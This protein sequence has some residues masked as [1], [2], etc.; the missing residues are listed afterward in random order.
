M[1]MTADVPDDASGVSAPRGAGQTCGGSVNKRIGS[2]MARLR[3]RRL[4]RRG[5]IVVAATGLLVGGGGIAFA[6]VAASGPIDGS[7]VIHGCYTNAAIN[8]SH[9]I[10]LQNAGTNCPSGTTAITWGSQGTNG[11]NGVSPTVASFTGSEGG[12]TNGGD[13]ITDADQN[14]TYVCDGTNGSDGSPGAPGLTGPSTAG[15]DGL[16]TTTVTVNGV[17]DATAQCPAA[18]PYILGGGAND[19]TITNGTFGALNYDGLAHAG[20]LGTAAEAPGV[21]YGWTGVAVTNT[22]TV[23]AFAICSD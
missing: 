12:C 21:A 14:T 1:C 20:Q 19:D 4:G 17:G 16:N 5:L 18:E 22:D 15:P 23:T 10:V 2:M 6:T 9:V 3:P 11:T 7:G 8:G 13:A